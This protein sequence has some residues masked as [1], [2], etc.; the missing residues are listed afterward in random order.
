VGGKFIGRDPIGFGGGDAN[1][2]RYVGN[3]PTN[4]IDP[5]GLTDV[6]KPRPVPP[7]E[8]PLPNPGNTFILGGP[9]VSGPDDP[10]NHR[11]TT[12]PMSYFC[13]TRGVPPKNYFPFESILDFERQV[14]RIQSV[15]AAN[16]MRDVTIVISMHSRPGIL[17]FGNN[18]RPNT[19]STRPGDSSDLQRF[20][21]ALRLIYRDTTPERT[22][23]IFIEG[24]NSFNYDP[25]TPGNPYG[26]SDTAL[27]EALF[28]A[29]KAA[30]GDGIGIYG[31]IGFSA[32]FG[33]NFMTQ[34]NSPGNGVIKYPPK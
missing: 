31:E 17:F 4:R 22:G 21:H 23:S 10:D 5:M 11:P 24:C 16:N 20:L 6:Y 28:A 29:I 33:N 8:F 34:G 12:A 2:Y 27:G 32:V 3:D 15:I 7:P 19:I 1:V 9:P 14:R 25:T 13:S 30:L 26:P 18:G